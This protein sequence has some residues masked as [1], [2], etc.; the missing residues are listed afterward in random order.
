MGITAVS[1]TG[2]RP[3]GLKK[4]NYEAQTTLEQ[5]LTDAVEQA[6][7]EGA[8]LFYSGMAIGTDLVAA[9]AVLYARKTHPQIRLIAVLPF[10][11]QAEKFDLPWKALYDQLLAM[12]DEVVCLSEQYHKNCFRQRNQFLVDHCDRLIAVYNG[13]TH[14][15][16][17]QTIRMAKQADKQL[18]I[19]APDEE[20]HLCFK[21][22]L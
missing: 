6:I 15:G 16:T 22:N 1:F 8:T 4:L 20:G 2:H 17:S 5:T 12:A 11:D 3:N 13:D 9:N 21:T 10:V 19:Y 14:S 18:W 7:G